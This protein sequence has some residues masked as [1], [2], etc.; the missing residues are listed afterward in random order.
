MQQSTFRRKLPVTGTES[1]TFDGNFCSCFIVTPH[2]RA[3]NEPC[4]RAWPPRFLLPVREISPRNLSPNFPN[5][6]KVRADRTASINRNELPF[7]YIIRLLTVFDEI[8]QLVGINCFPFLPLTSCT[9]AITEKY[10]RGFCCEKTSK[11]YS[12]GF[13]RLNKHEHFSA[14][15]EICLPRGNGILVCSLYTCTEGEGL[16]TSEFVAGSTDF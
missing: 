11:N 10:I 16:A 14:S 1:K 8:F 7:F 3:L 4:H 2:E 5:D 13:L 6:L 12:I 15:F 9:I